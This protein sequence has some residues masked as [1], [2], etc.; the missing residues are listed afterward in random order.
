MVRFC[1]KPWIDPDDAYGA[2]ASIPDLPVAPSFL[3]PRR[4]NR[5]AFPAAAARLLLYKK[6]RAAQVAAA[7]GTHDGHQHP[8]CPRDEA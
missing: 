3:I 8:P 1:N 4:L 2:P 6:M 7:A 5:I